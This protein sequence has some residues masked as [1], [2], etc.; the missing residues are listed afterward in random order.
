[1]EIIIILLIILNVAILCFTFKKKKGGCNIKNVKTPRP[2]VKPA[3][4]PK[5]NK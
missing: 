2:N 4:Q 3:P 1:M 5:K